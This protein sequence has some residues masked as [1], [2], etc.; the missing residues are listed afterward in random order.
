M[1]IEDMF[2]AAAITM[3]GLLAF[4]AYMY[5]FAESWLW[6]R[7]W[8]MGCFLSVYM[9]LGILRFGFQHVVVITDLADL[10]F[11][12]MQVMMY[13]IELLFGWLVLSLLYHAA[14]SLIDA[15]NGKKKDDMDVGV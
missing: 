5:H 7:V 9:E 2:V 11:S 13:A 12:A 8:L 14:R 15:A 1:A 6:K 4:F 3:G 10:T